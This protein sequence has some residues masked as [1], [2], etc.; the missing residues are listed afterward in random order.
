MSVNG[1]SYTNDLNYLVIEDPFSSKP[2]RFKS[3]LYDLPSVLSH[4][5]VWLI[6]WLT[7]CLRINQ[8]HLTVLYGKYPKGRLVRSSP[9]RVTP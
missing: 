4:L 7:G 1:H 8:K 3:M 6:G 9:Q 5:A 2:R